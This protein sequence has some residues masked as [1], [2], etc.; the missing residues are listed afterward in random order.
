MFS[1]SLSLGDTAPHGW[2]TGYVLS[3]LIVG[4]LLLLTFVLWDIRLGDKYALVPMSIWKDRNFSL[5]ISILSLGF[6]A[7]TPGTF[8][9]A[10]YLQNVT[11]FSP[12]LVAVH[13]LPM[14]VIGT[15]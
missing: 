9:Y 6:L 4:A 5:S 11:R 15:F 10:L 14:F 1:A 7:F 2:S 12:I 8:F 13:L 3:L